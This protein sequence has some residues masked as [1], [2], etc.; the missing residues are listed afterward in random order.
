MEMGNNGHMY[1]FASLLRYWEEHGILSENKEK[2]EMLLKV[3]RK[4]LS[5]SV[6]FLL[7]TIITP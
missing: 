5:A 6:P 4:L 7:L 3:I 1:A 2:G